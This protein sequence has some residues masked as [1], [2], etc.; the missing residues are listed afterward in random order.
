MIQ[1]SIPA[2]ASTPASLS[3]L[4]LLRLRCTFL[5]SSGSHDS[6]PLLPLLKTLT[7]KRR[8]INAGQPLKLPNA[9]RQTRVGKKQS[10]YHSRMVPYGTVY[11][12]SH[13]LNHP[14]YKFI[15]RT[16]CEPTTR[17]T[18]KNV[19]RRGLCP[20]STI[21]FLRNI[22]FSSHFPLLQSV[23]VPCLVINH[24]DSCFT[25]WTSFR[26]SKHW[27]SETGNTS[28]LN[29]QIYPK[30][31]PT[32]E[33]SHGNDKSPPLPSGPQIHSSD[34]LSHLPSPLRRRSLCI[35]KRKLSIHLRFGLLYHHPSHSHHLLH[36]FLSNPQ[37][38]PLGFCSC[39]I[40]GSVEWIFWNDL[41]WR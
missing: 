14:H 33:P 37:I 21:S 15:F 7:I 4:P 17:K 39:G 2:N 40:V 34:S 11:P 30:G 3:F 32:A 24:K 6:V 20:V 29:Q 9:R 25:Y 1:R 10:A 38:L 12:N 31:L 35:S 26:I 28:P 8:A 16:G 36:S 23:S 22:A 19:K 41:S 27:I 18:R 13:P 5:K